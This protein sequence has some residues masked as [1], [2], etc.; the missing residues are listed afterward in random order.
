MISKGQPLLGP[1]L[2]NLISSTSCLLTFVQKMGKKFYQFI[3]QII[4]SINQ[5]L[6]FEF[7]NEVRKKTVK[8]IYYLMMS[9]S[10]SQQMIEIFKLFLP[11]MVT[12]LELEIT[13]EWG[14]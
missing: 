3:M 8:I 11:K 1:E 5:L 2:M 14:I 9:C 12:L 10:D 6:D 13:L 4:P 7:S